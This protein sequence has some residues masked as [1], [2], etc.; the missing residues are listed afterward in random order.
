MRVRLQPLCLYLLLSGLVFGAALL[1]GC[2]L[3]RENSPPLEHSDST[4]TNSIGIRF[5]Y[6]PRGTFVMGSEHGQ[7]DEQPIH[8]VEITE[9]FFMGT[10]E[11]TQG[12]WKALMEENPSFFRGRYLPVDSVS[13][14]QAQSFIGRLNKKEDTDLYR[15]P[16]EAEW[17]YAA[18]GGTETR[19]Y[20]GDSSESLR[21]HA[22]YSFNS[23]RQSHPVGRKRGNPFGLHDIYGNV[24][25][26]TADAYETTFYKR[27]ERQNPLNQ[28]GLRAPR[29]IRG[30]GWFAVES[31]LRSANRGWARPDVGDE[32]LGFR[33]VRE[34]PDEKE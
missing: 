24:W 12:Q 3:R 17:E 33:I 34:I 15:L 1:G 6:V 9:P 20:F 8:E 4:F 26:W 11:V 22:W 32:Q 13:W 19:F 16:T 23:E 29:V 27:S 31:N 18:R 2:D 30:G 5:H 21:H 28:G 25:E 14:H 10:Y 7:D